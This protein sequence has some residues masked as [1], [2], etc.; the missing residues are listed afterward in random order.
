MFAEA[1]PA[2]KEMNDE[3]SGPR[4]RIARLITELSARRAESSSRSSE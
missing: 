2:K 3:S 4:H 1:L